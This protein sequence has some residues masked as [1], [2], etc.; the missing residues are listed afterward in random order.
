MKYTLKKPITVGEKG[1]PVTELVFREE[2]VAGD[3]RGIKLSSMADLTADEVCK[4][5]GRLCGQPDVVMSRLGI[6]DFAEV[7]RIINPFLN[8]GQPTG[9][10]PSPS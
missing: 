8:P 10:N 7:V 5:A 9:S 4:I 3:L 6:D 1:Q 2:V